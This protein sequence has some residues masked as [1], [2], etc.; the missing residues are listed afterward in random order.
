MSRIGRLPIKIPS[1]VT[2]AVKDGSVAIKGPKGTLSRAVPDFVAVQV[3]GG[4]VTVSRADDSQA[5]RERHGL[6]RTLVNNMVTG[7]ST[8]FEKKL[9]IVG[10]GYK[11]EVQGRKLVM[12]LGFSHPIEYPLPQ[13]IDVKVEKNVLAVAGADKEQVGQIAANI[14]GFRPPDSYKGK[15]IRYLGEQVRLK[16]GKAGAG[17][18]K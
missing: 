15:G 11:A 12:A 10:V 18:A 5:A 1:G 6:V 13:G 4:E 2:V 16:P 8:G 9:E 3:Q 14:R 7:V 17:A